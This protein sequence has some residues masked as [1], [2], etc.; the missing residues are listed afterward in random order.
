MRGLELKKAEEEIPT[1]WD[2]KRIIIG[3]VILVGLG[4][5]GYIM[6][7]PKKNNVNDD[8]GSKTLGIF[9]NQTE[10]EEEKNQ[11]RLPT[12]EDVENIIVDAK[13]TLSEITAENLTSSQAAIQKL[14]SDLQNLQGKKE[15]VDIICD[16]VCKNR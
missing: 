1:K 5:L 6:L 9:S 15:P 11:P 3:I 12:K 16:L 7:F 14:I 10:K 4:M 8:R 13:N 2:L